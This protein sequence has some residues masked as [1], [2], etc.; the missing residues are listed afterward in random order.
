M[1]PFSIFDVQ[2]PPFDF[3][4]SIAPNGGVAV[5]SETLAKRLANVD[6]GVFARRLSWDG[7]KLVD[8]TPDEAP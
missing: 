3:W 2:K 7:Q 1:T 5:L 8:S 6:S 4:L